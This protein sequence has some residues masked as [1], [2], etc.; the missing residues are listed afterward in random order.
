MD[1]RIEE[2]EKV[3]LAILNAT[4]KAEEGRERKAC[5]AWISNIDF[6]AQQSDNLERR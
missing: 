3:S 4:T 6:S 5:L 2:I 1:L